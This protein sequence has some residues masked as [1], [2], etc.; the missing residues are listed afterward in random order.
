MQ[1]EDDITAKPWPLPRGADAI[2]EAIE[3]DPHGIDCK[4]P[5][6]KLDA[7]KVRMDLLFADF[8]RALRAVAEVATAGA[9][10]YTDHGWLQVPDG[11]RRYTAALGRHLLD[12][13][14]GETHDAGTGLPHAAH[15]AWNALARLE[16][17]LRTLQEKTEPRHLVAQ[18]EGMIAYLQRCASGQWRWSIDDAHGEVVGGAGYTSAADAEKAIWT[19]W[20]AA[21]QTHRARS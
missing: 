7:G 9:A 20:R 12:E 8:P 1:D 4:Q 3:R 6:S 19:Q 21:V 5:G 11:E 18:G 17:A 14:C 15:A 2:A 16:L 10:K 13:H